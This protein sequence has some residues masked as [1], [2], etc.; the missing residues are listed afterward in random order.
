MGYTKIHA[1][2]TAIHEA[3]DS[4]QNPYQCKSI[5]AFFSSQIFKNKTAKKFVIVQNST[6]KK[7]YR[8]EVISLHHDTPLCATLHQ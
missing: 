8:L 3:I 6:L 1:L 4:I 7:V 2:K 5:S